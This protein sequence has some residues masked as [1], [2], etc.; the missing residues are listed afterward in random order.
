MAEVRKDILGKTAHQKNDQAGNI[1]IAQRTTTRTKD[2]RRRSGWHVE[3]YFERHIPRTDQHHQ[4]HAHSPI[5]TR[6]APHHQNPLRYRQQRKS[7]KTGAKNKK[8]QRRPRNTLSDDVVIPAPINSFRLLPASLSDVIPCP[9]TGSRVLSTRFRLG[10]RNDRCKKIAEYHS[11][12]FIVRKFYQFLL[13][14]NPAY[15]S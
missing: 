2:N 5:T 9:D 10:G 7:G 1:H 13:R 15:A 12:I 6:I 11:T 8:R 3:R 4:P 14:Y